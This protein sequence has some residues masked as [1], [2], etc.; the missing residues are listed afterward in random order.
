MSELG[1]L[2]ADIQAKTGIAVEAKEDAAAEC[3]DVVQG[4]GKTRFRFAF[5]PKAYIG[6]I[7]GDTQVEKNYALM[8]AALIEN[9]AVQEANLSK[10]EFLRNILLGDCGAGK[11]Q[12]YTIKYAVPDAP[13]FVLA[14]RTDKLLDEV[15]AMLMQSATNAADTVTAMDPH[16]C[17]FLKFVDESMDYQSAYDYAVF[18]GQTLYE[19]LGVQINIG[20]GTTVKNIYESMLSYQQ[21]ATT[22]RMSALF[23]N[24]GTVHTYREYV[25]IRMLEDLPE[26]R[27]GEYMSE[28]I[29]D[30]A[31]DIF[32][33]ED[34]M[35]TAEEFLQNSLNVSETSRNLYMHRNTLMYRLDKIER[36]T[37]LNI[38]KFSD[39]VS[40]RVLTI[41]YKLINK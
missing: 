12:K 26:Q 38:R 36:F 24:K 22:V 33:D 4:G 16:S 15:M 2:L 37:G 27:L 14:V 21:A 18:L 19:E 9:S 3:A 23:D 31:K 7:A 41:L 30:E 25:F 10:G 20:V 1:K 34:M 8:L 32:E 11:I 29:G 17:A 5:G 39:A 40:F 6:E 13:C 28:L 35:N